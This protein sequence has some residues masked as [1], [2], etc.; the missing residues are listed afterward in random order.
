L[1]HNSQSNAADLAGCRQSPYT[2][3]HP[4]V[5]WRDYQTDRYQADAITLVNVT[6]EK[7]S[8]TFYELAGRMPDHRFL[9]VVGG[10][11]KPDVRDLPNVELIDHTGD[12]R[13]VYART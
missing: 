12:M 3:V 5:D 7:G 4:P 9:G 6:G 2:I 13:A 10:W 8:D 1:V 11:G